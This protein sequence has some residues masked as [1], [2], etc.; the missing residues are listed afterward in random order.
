MDKVTHP[1]LG[2]IPQD[3][4]DL[5][6]Q[7]SKKKFPTIREVGKTLPI[8]MIDAQ[9]NRH[10]DFEL[11]RWDAELEEHLGEIM[12]RE[13]EMNLFAYTSEVI[14]ASLSRLGSIDV[15]KLKRSERR[16][17]VRR[18][19]LADVLFIY[20]WIRIEGLGNQFRISEFTCSSCGKKIQNFT[21]DLNSIEVKVLADIPKRKVILDGGVNFA[22]GVRKVAHVGPVFWS[23]LED[24]SSMGNAWKVKMA[25]I[26]NALI[27]LD[28]V[29]GPA[30]L[31]PA[32]FRSMSPRDVNKLVAEIDECGGGPVMELSDVHGG[33][34]GC[35]RRFTYAIPWTYDR[36]FAPSSH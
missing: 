6:G 23:F 9:G 4:L 24:L 12:E 30:H 25:S 19:Y 17:L 16:L 33:D 20:L 13:S 11:V 2:E 26:N 36:F 18:M 35:G 22:N 14:G 21:A 31:T 8:G 3:L 27:S 29:E 15:R 10:R 28:G 34:G 32:H 7:Q 1:I 5:D